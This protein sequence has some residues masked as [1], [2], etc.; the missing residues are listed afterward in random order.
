MKT[1][2]QVR[3]TRW[4]CR[5][6]KAQRGSPAPFLRKQP[7]YRDTLQENVANPAFQD[8]LHMNTSIDFGDFSAF[9]CLILVV[10][11]HIIFVI[12]P[13]YPQWVHPPDTKN[14]LRGHRTS[15]FSSHNSFGLGQGS[16]VL[17]ILAAKLQEIE[18]QEPQQKIIPKSMV[19]YGWKDDVKT[20]DKPDTGSLLNSEYAQNR[21]SV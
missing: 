20:R 9:P 15:C 12:I 1:I 5:L 8:D 7:F 14:Y 19:E 10:I 17:S 18:G 4:A 3:G 11:S 13:F 21:K 16:K 6:S 2:I